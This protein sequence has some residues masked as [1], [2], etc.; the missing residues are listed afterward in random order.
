MNHGGEFSKDLECKETVNF[1]KTLPQ[2]FVFY[3]MKVILGSEWFTAQRWLKL[4]I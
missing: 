3:F 2:A 4:D 1:F